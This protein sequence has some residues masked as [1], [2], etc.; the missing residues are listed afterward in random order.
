MLSADTLLCERMKARYSENVQHFFSDLL[1][2]NFTE[3]ELNAIP[4]LF[5]PAWGEMYCSSILKIA[6]A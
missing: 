6:I 4:A 2:E 3:E 1:K 5:L